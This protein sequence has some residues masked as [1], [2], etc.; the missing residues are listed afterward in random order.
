M[1]AEDKK[2]EHF[3]EHFSRLKLPMTI[4]FHIFLYSKQS[5]FLSHNNTSMNI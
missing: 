1:I 2:I 4:N 5:I 3:I